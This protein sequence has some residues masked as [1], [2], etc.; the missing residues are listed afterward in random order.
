LFKLIQANTK[1]TIYLEISLDCSYRNVK[2]KM[3]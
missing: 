3:Q 1:E 2:N